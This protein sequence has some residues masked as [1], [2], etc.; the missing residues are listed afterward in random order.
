MTKLADSDTTP[1][2]PGAAADYKW[3]KATASGSV[4]TLKATAV[5]TAPNGRTIVIS[6]PAAGDPGSKATWKLVVGAD[7]T[8]PKTYR[9]G[10]IK[11]GTA[12][13]AN[14]PID[15]PDIDLT[16]GA[17]QSSAAQTISNAINS[18]GNGG[19]TAT[20][21]GNEVLITAPIVGTTT[22]SLTVSA[23]ASYAADP[24]HGHRHHRQRRR[25]HQDLRHRHHQGRHHH[26]QPQHSD[27]R[28]LPT[29][30]ARP[31]R[32]LPPPPSPPRST[33]PAIRRPPPTT[34]SP[35]KARPAPRTT[36]RPSRP[37]HPA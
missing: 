34:S 36:A 20:W 12:I 17:G 27:P 29:S 33:R 11:V 24:R 4:V 5:G 16:T 32:P 8:G 2:A 3:Y 18:T 30:P 22:S 19:Y 1:L 14:D 9:I 23:P 35:S 6:G 26:C 21:S 37:R 13:L 7:T 28:Q 15:F 25:R 31:D 10:N